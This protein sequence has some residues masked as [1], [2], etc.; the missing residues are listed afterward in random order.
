[1]QPR[2]LPCCLPLDVGNP[3]LLS[4]ALL[5]GRFCLPRFLAFDR[6][7]EGREGSGLRRRPCHRSEKS[8]AGTSAARQGKGLALRGPHG[9]QSVHVAVDNMQAPNGARGL[10][11]SGARG[12]INDGPID[13]RRHSHGGSRAWARGWW[14]AQ[15]RHA[16]PAVGVPRLWSWTTGFL[17]P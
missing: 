17:A 15:S 13:H 7:T 6:A 3:R 4:A 9:A 12:F 2:L 14:V 10:T 11:H 8:A 16:S 1:M 5:V